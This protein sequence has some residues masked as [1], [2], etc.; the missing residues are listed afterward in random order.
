MHKNVFVRAAAV[1]SSLALLVSVAACGDNATS[2]NGSSAA[3]SSS[4]VNISGEFAGAGASS[5]KSAV[6]A[7]IAGFQQQYPD[8]QIAYDPSGSGAGVNSFLQGNALWA[9]SDASLSDDQV[10]QSSSRCA[11]GTTAFDIPVY[12]SPIAIVYNLS[13][14]GFNGSDKHIQM[15]ADTVAKIFDGKITKWNDDAIKAENPGVDL[16]DLA[17]TPVYRSDKSG[18]TKNFQ[19]YLSQA[20]PNSWSYE[21]GENWPGSAG[22]GASGTSGVISTV[23]QAQGTIGYADASQAG[24]LGTVAVKVGDEYVPYSAEAAA[25]VVDASPQDTSAKGDNRIV[26]KIDHATTA[27]GAY[28]VVLVSYDVACP[29]YEKA[30]DAQFVKQWL[31]Y[32]VSEDGQKTAADNAGSA[33][34]SDTLRQKVLAS[35]NNIKTE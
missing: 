34:M 23:K 13:D 35:I 33:P 15:S 5:Q 8:A 14:A 29:A 32:V 16:P 9:G 30:S 28:P 27:E 12:I 22:Q 18:T 24:E 10:S 2:D 7:W 4:S 19:N 1:A 20:A 3:S 31:T 25:K 6:D 17:I 11:N 21:P 26:I